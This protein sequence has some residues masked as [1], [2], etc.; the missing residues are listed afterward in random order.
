MNDKVSIYN[1]ETEHTDCMLL[2]NALTDKLLPT[3]FEN[4]TVIEALLEHLPEFSNR[5]PDLYEAFKR[6]GFIVN[7]DFDELAFIKLQNKRKVFAHNNYRITINPTLDCNLKCW[8]CSVDYAGTKHNRER[9]SDETVAALNNHISSLTTQKKAH[10]ISLDWF[11]GEPML[12]YDEVVSKVSASA[13][14][15]ASEQKVLFRQQMTTNATLLSEERIRE[16]K[17]WG[18]YSFQI[19][20][21]GNER[22]HNKIKFYQD[23]Q[24]TYRKIVENINLLAE[25]IPTV[26]IYLRINYDRQTLKN[27][28]D[29]LPDF[30]EKSKRCIS[31]DFQRVWQVKCTDKERELLKDAKEYF[32]QAGFRSEFWAYSP[33]S[34]RRCYADSF[35]YYA[36]HYNGKVFK[37]TARD[38]NDDIAIGHLLNSGKIE[39]N[40][41][42]LSKYFETAP[43]ENGVCEKCK[44]FPLCMGPCVQKSYELRKRNEPMRCI[45]EDVEY[46]LKDYVIEKARKRNLIK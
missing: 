14:S 33:N 34:F 3:N 5:F 35:L 20:I 37:C 8:Y 2:Y 26:L 6:A 18:F 45:C 40:D 1:I 23:K 31:V 9:M 43:F 39:W 24:G 27:I 15:V 12:Y 32:R 16:M 36:V 13:V 44:I 17:D 22:R 28:Q 11:G 4:Y 7:S 10:S 46:S 38:Y 42:L 41:A 29:I 30:T 25:I 21:D 19:P